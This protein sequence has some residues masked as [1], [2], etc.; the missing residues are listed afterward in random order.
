L[1]LHPLHH[2]GAGPYAESPPPSSK[3]WFKSDSDSDKDLRI[4]DSD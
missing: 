2:R 1:D 4:P 3:D